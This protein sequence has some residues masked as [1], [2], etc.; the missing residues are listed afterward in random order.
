MRG[1]AMDRR[2]GKAAWFVRVVVALTALT[3]ATVGI[4]SQAAVAAAPTDA[5]VLVSGI[6]TTTPFT[7]PSA[8]CKGTYP[9]GFTW[10]YDG[11]RLAAAGY[12]VY[13][14]PVND[15]P[16]P[17]APNPRQFTGCPPQL[18][19]SMTI[20]S[21]G[22]I[23]ANARA[24]ASFIAYLHSQLGVNTVRF[25]SHSYGGLWTRGAIRL[26]ST[27][28]PSVQ[29]Q[30]VTTLGTPHLG[31]FM[32]DIG[33]GVDPSL[34]GSD[35][36]CK[37]IAYLLIAYRETAFEPAMSQVTAA[38]IAQWNPGQGTTLNGIPVTAI[39]GDAVS[40]PGLTSPYIS[41]N[42]LLV[43]IE[44]AQAV[45]LE[46]SG[47]IPKL[48]CFAAFPDVHSNTFLP[49]V[50]SVKY[51][52]LSDPNVV[53]DVQQTLAGNPP[54]S[55]CP[56]PPFGSGFGSRPPFILDAAKDE[57][58]V[59]LRI[60]ASPTASI[61]GRQASDAA[62]IVR[63]GT[64]VTCGRAMLASVPFMGSNRI[65]V[66]QHPACGTALRATPNRGMLFLTDAQ[67]S[68]RFRVKGRRIYVDLQGSPNHRRLEVAIKHGRRFVVQTLDRRHSLRIAAAVRDVTLR[69]RLRETDGRWAVAV[70]TIQ[71]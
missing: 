61:T 57:I 69:V 22:D 7:T 23:Y 32:A 35:L 24:L 19:A 33:E 10:T 18:P 58:T 4:G 36:A 21:R 49:F 28:F 52:L 45:G 40:I 50:P 59:P 71:V 42:D 66:I 60:A 62:I 43:G 30:S 64:R 13:T 37:A 11:A 56:N 41:P 20:N 54:T 3:G 34:C 6:T 2:N 47:V 26:A 8:I 9:R 17:V 38:A 14:A 31:S 68:V 27:S 39:G 15:G 55:G 48:S 51:S 25:V 70:A 5:V 63:A 1:M 16:G 67:Q 29:V 65:S 46:Q 53:T 12:R 44:S